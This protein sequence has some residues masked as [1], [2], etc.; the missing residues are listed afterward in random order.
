[1]QRECGAIYARVFAHTRKKAEIEWFRWYWW[2]SERGSVLR[3]GLYYCLV[4]SRFVCAIQKNVYTAISDRHEEEVD[5]VV[6][7]E[8]AIECLSFSRS[9]LF[10]VYK[11]AIGKSSRHE[12]C[13]PPVVVGLVS[14]LVDSSGPTAVQRT[15]TTCLAPVTVLVL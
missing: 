14:F 4:A 5:V 6:E 3:G 1:M 2:D 11:S 8:C 10:S 12:I 13:N 7:R 9:L 15:T